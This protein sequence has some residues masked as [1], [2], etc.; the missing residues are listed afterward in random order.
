M[1][2]VPGPGTDRPFPVP[3]PP[4]ERPIPE[5]EDEDEQ[6]A[7]PDPEEAPPWEPAPYD[8]EREYSEPD[9][10]AGVP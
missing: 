4:A 5:R 6:I 10:P 2:T 3:G 9:V 8:P 7:S 1:A